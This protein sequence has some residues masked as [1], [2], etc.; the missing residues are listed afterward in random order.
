VVGSARF[1]ESGVL[2]R[3]AAGR[4]AADPDALPPEGEEY[5]NVG[6]VQVAEAPKRLVFTITLLNPDGS[7]RLENLTTVD[8]SDRGAATEVTVQV[9]VLHAAANARENLAGMWDGWSESLERLA[10]TAENEARE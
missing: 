5:L 6:L 9:Q 3:P 8:L 4:R 1:H 2:D 7:R 10:Q